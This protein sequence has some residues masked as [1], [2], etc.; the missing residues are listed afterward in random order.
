MTAIS[1]TRLRPARQAGF[2]MT[3]ALPPELREMPGVHRFAGLWYLPKDIVPAQ[4]EPPFFT[5]KEGQLNKKLY[6][7]QANAV[8]AALAATRLLLNLGPGLGKTPTAIECLRLLDEWLGSILII[9]PAIVRDTW[10]QE[11]RAWAPKLAP[12]VEIIETGK[13]AQATQARIIVTSYELAARVAPRPWSAIIYDECHYLRNPDSNRAKEAR[14]ILKAACPNALRLFLTG[15]PIANE[16]ADLHNQVDLLYPGLWGKVYEFRERYCR[17]KD[18]THSVSGVEYFG[19]REDRADELKLRLSRIAAT[20][21]DEEIKGLLP[22]I[23]FQVVRVKPTKAFDLRSYL[24][25]FDR[26]DLH[27]SRGRDAAVGACGLAKIDHV[28]ELVKDAL[29]SGSSHIS[30]MTHLKSTAYALESALGGL[31]VDIACVTG[32]NTHKS[33]HR[34][35][36]KLA[37]RPKAIFVATMHSIGIGINELVSFPEVVYAELDYRPDEVVQSMKRYHRVSGQQPVRIRALILE[38]TLEERVAAVVARKLRDQKMVLDMG[39]AENALES[40]LSAKMSDEDF[41]A[42]V[43]AAAAQM[44]ERDEYC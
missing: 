4:H 23:R 26:R 42:R 3:A 38:G 27:N 8:T 43:Q 21:T 17:Q 16:P 9:S 40:G 20:A 13:Q 33:R 44:R 12:E 34:E 1:T 15:T 32:E 10:L 25:N 11:F 14:I 5:P 28:V 41:F 37:A 30:V 35:M 24:D 18:N 6:L 29:E 22:P 36:A 19:L 39:P 31:G 2:Y 7:Y